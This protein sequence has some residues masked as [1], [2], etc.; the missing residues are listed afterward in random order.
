MGLKTE[1]LFFSIPDKGKMSFYSKISRLILG[2]PSNL[3]PVGNVLGPLSLKVKKWDVKLTSQ[4]VMLRLLINGAT[5]M[6]L[7]TAWCLS[8]QT[9]NITLH[10]KNQV[11]L[12]FS[13]V[14]TK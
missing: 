3:S 14:S 4:H 11:S 12:G 5:P 6:L 13:H 1:T 7:D 8:K 10:H 9:N 2:L